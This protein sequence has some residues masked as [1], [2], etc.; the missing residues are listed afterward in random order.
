MQALIAVGESQMLEFKR[1]GSTHL[2]REICAFANSLGGRVLIGVDDSGMLHPLNKPNTLRSQV[3]SI[4][5]NLD[6]P[7]MVDCTEVEGILVVT[8]PESRHKPH[9]SS[10]KFYLREGA[11]CQQMNRDEIREFFYREGLIYFEEKINDRYRWPEDFQK[12]AFDTFLKES[13][14]TPVFPAEVIL[15]NLGLLKQDKMSYAGSLLFSK[16]GSLFVP[17]A[18]INCCLFQGTTTTR[19]LDQKIYDADL[20]TNYRSTVNYLLAHLNTAYEIGVDRKEQLEIPEGAMREALINAMAH[21]DY[22]KPGDLQLHIFQNR[23]EIINPGGLVGGMTI[24]KLGTVSLPR[25]PLLFGM[26]HRMGLVEK[27]GSGMKRI[28]D[29]CREQEISE[30]EIQADYDWFRIIFSR[31]STGSGKTGT[32]ILERLSSMPSMTIP[33]LAAALNLSTRTIEKQIAKLKESGNLIRV[34]S[35]KDGHWEV[36]E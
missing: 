21:R 30:P 13:R 34:G 15:Q 35:R 6:P 7:I 12:E 36:K 14:I 16:Q 18:S 17:G 31:K 25:N 3:Q 20:L 33:E 5:R 27:I 4:A 2:A 19:V 26:M 29:M 8:V 28:A 1:A 10:G 24:E 9:S 11:S 23:V 32:L 22:R